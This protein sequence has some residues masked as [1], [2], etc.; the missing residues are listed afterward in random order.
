MEEGARGK[1]GSTE[2]LNHQKEPEEEK[3][4]SAS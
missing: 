4:G 2:T 3:E 1:G